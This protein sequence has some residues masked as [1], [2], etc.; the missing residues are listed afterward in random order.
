MTLLW[1]PESR[2]EGLR[3][4]IS[5]HAISTGVVD[6]FGIELDNGG[7][8][9]HIQSAGQ[10]PSPSTHVQRMHQCVEHGFSR[11]SQVMVHD[12]LDASG[13]EEQVGQ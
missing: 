13:N 5:L 6:G 10:Y 3:Q 11:L 7:S 4:P 12:E 9:H 1:I 2:G 8:Q